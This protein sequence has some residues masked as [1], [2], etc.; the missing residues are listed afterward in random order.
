MTKISHSHSP[1]RRQFFRTSAKTAG[2]LSAL[3]LLPASIQRALA[4]PAAVET[5]T[6]KDI[7]HIVILMQENR[8]FDHYFGTMRGVRGVGDRF[9][10]PLANGKSVVFQ[11]D[12]EGGQEVQ[13]FHRG[14]TTSN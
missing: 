5:G 7:K 1:G 14:S 10:I 8:S 13:P 2:A 3:A 6:I 9:P 4:I 11:P 12:A